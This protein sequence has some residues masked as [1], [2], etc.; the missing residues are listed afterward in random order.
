MK[1]CCDLVDEDVSGEEDNLFRVYWQNRLVPETQ[2]S[3]M[4]FFPA[5]KTVLQCERYKI[6]LDWKDRIRGFIFFD[7]NFVDISNNKL[8]IKADPDFDTW[9][10]DKQTKKKITYNPKSIDK[11]FERSVSHPLLVSCSCSTLRFLAFCSSSLSQLASGVSS[12]L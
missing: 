3:Q 11:D 1:E 12:I 5:A 6:P 4:P 9:I 2:L 10:N 7:S 8:K